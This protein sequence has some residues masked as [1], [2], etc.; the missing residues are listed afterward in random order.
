MTTRSKMSELFQLPL[1]A[2]VDPRGHGLRDLLR[3]Q[4]CAE[5]REA[6]QALFGRVVVGVSF[7]MAYWLYRGQGIQASGP[8]SI[9][10]VWLL[11][12]ACT[13]GCT[14]AALKARHR[15]DVLLVKSG[16]RRIEVDDSAE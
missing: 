5:V 7:P 16:G 1:S 3:A 13:I 15:V 9:F 12:F 2:Q 8:R 6:W 10:V 11:A 14:V 4:S